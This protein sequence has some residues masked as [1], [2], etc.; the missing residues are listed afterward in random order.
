MGGVSSE[1]FNAS[2]IVKEPLEEMCGVDE[3]SVGEA[4]Q[5]GKYIGLRWVD[6]NQGTQEVLRLRSRLVDKNLP[7]ENK[8]M[9]FSPYHRLPPTSRCP[10]SRVEEKTRLWETTAYLDINKVFLHNEMTWTVHIE[11][12]SEDPCVREERSIGGQS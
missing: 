3:R 4:D 9:T 10:H 6:E 5:Q 2:L 8:E 7:I 1:P 12:Q 11:L